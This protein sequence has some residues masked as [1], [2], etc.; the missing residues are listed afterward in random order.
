MT[1]L[2][3]RNSIDRSSS[4]RDVLLIPFAIALACFAL[5]PTARADDDDQGNCNTAEGN[6]A[7][8]SNTTGRDNTANGFNALFNNTTG[9]SNTAN[10]VEALYSN[11]NGS[12]KTARG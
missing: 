6:S 9:G 11:I 4:R 1:T 3:L 12:S 8:N 2:H 10:G 7:L 5:L